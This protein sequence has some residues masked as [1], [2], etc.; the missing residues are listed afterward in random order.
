MS[1]TETHTESLKR[2][3]TESL[4]LSPS[5]VEWLI[6]VWEAIQFFDDV[7]D[8]DPV[9][10]DRLD[11]VLWALFVT[12]PQNRFYSDHSAQLSAILATQIMKWQASDRSERDG[13]ADQKSYVWRAG[14]YD[15]VLYCCVLIHGPEVTAMAAENI[16]RLYGEDYVNYAREFEN[17]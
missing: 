11:K 14:Y 9:S 10:R 6:V 15:L 13:R 1:H 2:N 16:L 5:A 7:A 17:A 3:F 12:G 8:N 4:R